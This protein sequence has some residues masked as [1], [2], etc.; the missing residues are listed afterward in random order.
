M[1]NKSESA[2][3]KIREKILSGALLPGDRLVEQSLSEEIGVNR[4]DTRQALARLCAEGLAD[5]GEKGGYFIKVLTDKDVDE[6]YEVRHILETSAIPLIIKRAGE[7]DYSELE[8]IAGHMQLMA[9]HGYTLGVCEADL[10]FHISLMKAAHNERL[11]D[12]YMKA[13]IPLSG[14]HGIKH[15][16]T[17]VKS[18]DMD[19][20]L[21]HKKIIGHLRNG[22]ADEA[23]LLLG[24]GYKNSNI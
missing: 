3:A 9:E 7:E 15:E 16:V 10:K 6:I 20:V 14:V 8:A 22:E 2:Y 24:T 18:G 21:E 23:V 11:F 12:L 1:K 13:N 5:R 19:D 17:R 4:G